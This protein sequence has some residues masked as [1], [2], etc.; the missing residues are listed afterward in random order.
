MFKALPLLDRGAALA[1]RWQGPEAL[2]T[3][4]PFC[5]RRSFG[6]RFTVRMS[7]HKQSLQVSSTRG[8][9]TITSIS[10]TVQTHAI[11][12]TSRKI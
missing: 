10:W 5:P 9:T 11:S 4:S 1:G 2:P 3:Q 12:M 7:A 6:R 8:A